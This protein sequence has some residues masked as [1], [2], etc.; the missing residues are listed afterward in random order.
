MQRPVSLDFGCPSAGAARSSTQSPGFSAGGG[1]GVMNKG[2]GAPSHYSYRSD[3][4]SSPGTPNYHRRGTAVAGYQQ[5]CDSERVIPPANRHRR[6]PGSSMALPYNGGK[7]LP[8]KWE[9]A[10]RWIFSPNPSSAPG[11]SL[12]Q[13]WRPKS[14]SGPIGPP[15]RFGGPCSSVSSSVMFLDNGGVGKATVNSPFLAGV[16]LPEHV[17]GANTHNG[18]DLSEALGE[19]SNNGQGCRYG[20]THDGHPAMHFT[21]I[22]RQ[23]ES[24]QSLPASHESTQGTCLFVNT[25]CVNS[26]LF[27][28]SL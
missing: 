4:L 17:C 8:S 3:V 14:K 5:G 26:W 15:N 11:R 1:V 9:D 25:L 19:A 16:L 24:Y 13:L 20:Q 28:L 7:I 2:L 27:L 22:S 10:E 18:K 21:R 6:H 23:F 12:P